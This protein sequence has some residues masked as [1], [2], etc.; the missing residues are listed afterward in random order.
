MTASDIQM[1]PKLSATQPTFDTE[2]SPSKYIGIKPPSNDPREVAEE[3]FGL[4]GSSPDIPGNYF[5]MGYGGGPF[6]PFY[7]HP[8]QFGI[9]MENF[10]QFLNTSSSSS[11][12]T[13][14][15]NQ[16]GANFPSYF[17]QYAI[18]FPI[19]Y[20]YP[21]MYNFSGNGCVTGSSGAAPKNAAPKL[22]ETSIKVLSSSDQMERGGEPQDMN[23]IT[24]GK[25][26]NDMDSYPEITSLSS[27]L[28]R[29]KVADDGGSLAADELNISAYFADVSANG[30]GS[31][32]D[33]DESE[34]LPDFMSFLLKSNQQEESDFGHS[35]NLDN[36]TLEER[37]NLEELAGNSDLR[38]LLCADLENS[39][40]CKKDESVHIEA[41][42]GST[43]LSSIPNIK[44]NDEIPKENHNYMN[45]GE[46]SENGCI[47]SVDLHDIDSTVT[48]SR[49]DNYF[50]PS[51]D[52]LLHLGD[53]TIVTIKTAMNLDIQ[54]V[55][56]VSTEDDAARVSSPCAV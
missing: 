44:N 29:L 36:F 31:D 11:S 9:P 35:A 50:L 20:M 34:E 18:P 8:S 24:K 32:E 22:A 23:D 5:S 54:G 45:N 42:P 49:Q 4:G 41:D 2:K 3:L 56:E 30:I 19:Q 25:H 16:K 40:N 13:S 28:K 53:N 43:Y 21:Q 12:S 52:S 7:P 55:V 27:P 26:Q 17:Q 47:T 46:K 39:K 51:L 10:D 14:P 48:S 15:L 38:A 37:K 1:K 6:M 33:V